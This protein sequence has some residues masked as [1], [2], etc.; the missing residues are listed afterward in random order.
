[1][2]LPLRA[3][4]RRVE[5]PVAGHGGRTAWTVLALGALATFAAVAFL[6]APVR[7]PDVTYTW[8][9]AA[10]TAVALPLMPYQ[11][12][13]LVASVG[14][15]EARRGGLLLATVPPRPDPAAI[16]L[17]GLV[18]TGTGAEVQIM[19]GGVY[20][21][22]LALP[23]GDCSIMLAARPDATVVA[24][25]GVPV[26]EHRGD[27]RPA[28]TGVFTDLGSGSGIALSLTTD[29][30]FATSPSP[31]KVALPEMECR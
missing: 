19:S 24:L 5:R 4:S 13:E 15:A 10:G 16:P 7:Q 29:T 1:V 26:L 28:V 27:V 6:V 17:D 12:T 18:V 2:L 3:G 25:E 20:L 22:H 14:C 23:S 11:P 31:L 21:G 9:P 8:T 30:R